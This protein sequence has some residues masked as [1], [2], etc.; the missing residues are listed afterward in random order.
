MVFIIMKGRAI[1]CLTAMRWGW[2]EEEHWTSRDAGAGRGRRARG[3]LPRGAA[4]PA[5]RR[6]IVTWA[7]SRPGPPAA[8]GAAAIHTTFPR[9][10]QHA[11]SKGHT[12]G[13]RRSVSLEGISSKHM[14]Y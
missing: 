12:H 6:R 9:T 13:K 7:R 5:R 4:P 14:G 8:G 2:E 10:Q 3:G 1:Q 11:F